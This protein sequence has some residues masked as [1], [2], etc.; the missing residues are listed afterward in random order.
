MPAQRQE[1]IQEREADDLVDGVVSADIF[2]HDHQAAL[3]IEERGGVQSSRALERLL[4]RP[5]HAG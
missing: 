4:R 2:P 3:V 1:A 5:H